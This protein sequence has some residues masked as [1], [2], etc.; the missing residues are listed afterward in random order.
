MKVRR[1]SRRGESKYLG[2]RRWVGGIGVGG[3]CG[4]CGRG[5][6]QREN[7]SSA[8]APRHECMKVRRL[9]RR[10]ESKYLGG[11]EWVGGI[12]VGGKCDLCGR[13][14]LQR[15][16]SSRALTHQHRLTLSNNVSAD[17]VGSHGDVMQ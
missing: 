16:N 7:S 14:D 10:D 5:D 4:L 6:L 2:G 8:L 15:E 11:R 3:K 12:G 13:G 17:S 9:S 1:L